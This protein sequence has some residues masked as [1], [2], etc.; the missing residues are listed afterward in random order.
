ME[1]N[2][3]IIYTIDINT[4]KAEV[5]IG[6]VTKSFNDFS[7]GADFAVK[8]AKEFSGV[9]SEVT[10]RNIEMIDKTGLAGAT[11]QE[12]G[13]TISDSNYG[14]RGMANNLQQLS[15]LFITLVSTSGGL[16]NGLRQLGKVLMGPLG[17]VILF[18]TFITLLEGGKINISV[19]AEGVKELNKAMREGA[20]NAGAEVAELNILVDT[21]K[22]AALSTE[23]R[24]IAIDKLNKDY[25]E[26]LGNINLE[27]IETEN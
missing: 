3:N 6:K 4:G 17:I 9:T 11:V 18:Q 13:R 7:K 12:F 10:K 23:E 26:F 8:K 22:N 14:I 21:A 16:I 27:T 25:P 20:K 5:K 15:S 1:E 24:Q 19:F 2:K